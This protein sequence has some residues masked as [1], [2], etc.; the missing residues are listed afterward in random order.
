MGK[1]GEPTGYWWA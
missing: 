1:Q